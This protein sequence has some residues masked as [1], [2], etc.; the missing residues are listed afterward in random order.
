MKRLL[1]V[2][3]GAA[4]TAAILKGCPGGVPGPGPAATPTPRPAPTPTP[5]PTP[6]PAPYVPYKRVELGR[7]FNDVQLNVSFE[8]EVGTTASRDREQRDAYT[9]D[10]KLKVRVPKPHQDLAELS[11]LNAALPEVLPALPKMLE[12]AKISPVYDDLYR[13][14]VNAVQQNVRRLDA[15]LTRHNFFDC[16]T[17]LELEHPTT[18][19]RAL[20]LQADMDTDTDGSDAD[21]APE[22]DGSSVTFQPMTSYRWAKRT[23]NQNSFIPPREA[24]LRQVTQ[25]LATAS[26]ARQAELKETQ[27]RLRDE[28][29]D[30]K[31]HS[32]LVAHLDPFIVLPGVLFAARNRSPYSPQVGDLCVVIHDRKI[33]PAVVGDVGPMAVAGEASLRIC[34]QIN[35]R[36]SSFNRPVSDLKVTYLLFPGTAERPFAPPDLAKWNARCDELL[37]EI[38]GYGGELHVWEDLTK[39]KATPVPATPAPATPAPATPAPA[40][41]APS[42]TPAPAATPSATPGATPAATPVAGSSAPRKKR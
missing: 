19:R 12:T 13:V 5:L 25:E 4:V 34:Q 32:F 6:T 23:A 26:P 3:A 31:K 18:K 14:K 20:L 17:I 39:P 11:R 37:K 2:L 35:A 36:A 21:R 15:V 7:I 27:R 42:A 9:V 10:V 40:G 16:E 41:A 38:G 22:V 29:A 30:L 24:K 1:Y 33:Y 8:S 28:I